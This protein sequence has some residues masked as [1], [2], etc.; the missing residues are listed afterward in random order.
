MVHYSLGSPA[1]A[2]VFASQARKVLIYHGVTPIRYLAGLPSIRTWAEAGEGGIGEFTKRTQAA[3][4]H[5]AFAADDLR[6]AGYQDVEVLPYT[7]WERLYEA[8]PAREILDRYRCKGRKYLLVVGRIMPHKRV[9]D[10]LFVLDYLRNQI[11]SDWQLV[12]VGSSSGADIYRERLVSLAQKM[13]LP[14]LIWTG[15]VTQE[16]L[17]AFYQLADAFLLTSEHEGFG[18]PLVEALRY[19]V[20]IFACDSAAVPEILGDSGVL[21]YERNWPLVAET[22]HL[23]TEDPGR[24]ENILAS[25]RARRAFFSSSSA[26]QRWR[27]WLGRFA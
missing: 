25:Q 26:E 1:F 17:I 21:F 27:E 23:V 11:G 16:A 6:R 13:N 20:P 24:N 22:I 5:S 14:D 2:S 8:L 15:P 10:S 4:A 18:V 7:L 9:E 19:D 3:I 12:I